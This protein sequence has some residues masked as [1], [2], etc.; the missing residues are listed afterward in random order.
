MMKFAIFRETIQDGKKKRK[1]LV[2]WDREKIANELE[3]ELPGASGAFNTIIENF[4]KESIK[5]P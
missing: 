5:I 3:K 4:K 2:E 1:V